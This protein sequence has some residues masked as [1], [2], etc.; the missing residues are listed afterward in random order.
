MGGGGQD[1][2]VSGVTTGP[3]LVGPTFSKHS[4]SS[5]DLTAI[6]CLGRIWWASANMASNEVA[7]LK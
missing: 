5:A 1:E 4:T 2:K 6:K 3:G 7:I